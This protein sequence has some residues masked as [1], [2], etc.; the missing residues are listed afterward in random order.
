MTPIIRIETEKIKNGNYLFAGFGSIG[1][2]KLKAWDADLSQLVEGE[3]M[4]EYCD[5]LTSF[6]ADLSSLE[7]GAYMFYDCSALQTFDC[8]AKELKLKNGGRMFALTNSL[9]T[10][11]YDLPVLEHGENMFAGSGIESFSSKLD[12]I[13]HSTG[14]F[15]QC[16]ALTKFESDLKTLTNADGMFFLSEAYGSRELDFSSGLGKL[17]S[18]I[19]MF[20]NRIL[21][22]E[23][24]GKIAGTIPH[25][26]DTRAR[27][28]IGSCTSE[29]EGRFQ[30]NINII[31]AKGWHVEY[32]IIDG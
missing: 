29:Q 7:N 21:S 19:D 17:S 12:S 22:L 10:F 4:F 31:Q 5:K 23:A 20:K 26:K 3:H 15:Q 32:D 25:T 14:M 24:V 18:G 11:D 28:H 30:P 1:G 16:P 13:T 2:G 9:K 6:S 8:K 27:I